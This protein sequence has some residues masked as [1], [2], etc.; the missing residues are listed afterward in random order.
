MLIWASDYYFKTYL[1]KCKP[2][3]LRLVERKKKTP[4]MAL[5][6]HNYIFAMYSTGQY[7]L[8]YTALKQEVR[9]S[10]T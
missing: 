10:Y 4:I 7:M 9:K 8:L 6:K 3:H 5:R 1:K 2:N